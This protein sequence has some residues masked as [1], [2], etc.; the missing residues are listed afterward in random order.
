MNAVIPHSKL[1]DSKISFL[2]LLLLKDSACQTL[3][4]SIF[5]KTLNKYLCIPFESF[6]FTS[7]KKIKGELKRYPRNSSSFSSFTET[8]LLFWKRLRLRVILPICYYPFREISYSNRCKW[9]SKPRKVSTQRWV[10][11][12]TTFNGSHVGIKK[13]ILKY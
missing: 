13:V 6:H 11:F 10:V 1:S 5:Q 8:P 9:L 2:D 4:N 3:L 12:K 7:N